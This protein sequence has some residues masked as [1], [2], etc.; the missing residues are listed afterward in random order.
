MCVC[1]PPRT[2]I[3][4]VSV[5]AR[6]EWPD[7]LALRRFFEDRGVLFEHE[8]V[9]RDAAALERMRSLSHQIDQSIVVIGSKVF[10]GFSPAELERALP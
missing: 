7:Y 8:D 1:A 2:P 3:E 9:G 10:I 4:G 5:Y 6:S